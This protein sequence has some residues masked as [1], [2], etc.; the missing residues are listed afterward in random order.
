MSDQFSD[1]PL[2]REQTF[3][4]IKM[5]E[6]KGWAVKQQMFSSV[7]WLTPVIFALMAFSFTSK[8][9]VIIASLTAFVLAIFLLL[10]VLLSLAHASKDYVRAHEVIEYVRRSDLFPAEILKV[11][12]EKDD[13]KLNKILP[14]IGKQFEIILFFVCIVALVSLIVAI[15]KLS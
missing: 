12:L 3:G 11:M 10:L 8:N 13:Q 4:L 9:Y 1:Q 15:W 14:F 5:Y 7:S 2:N 6:D